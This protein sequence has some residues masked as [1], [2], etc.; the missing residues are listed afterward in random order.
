[1]AGIREV[2]TVVIRW[3]AY[4]ILESQVYREFLATKVA[5]HWLLL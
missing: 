2:G 4:L 1:M 3:I 5:D